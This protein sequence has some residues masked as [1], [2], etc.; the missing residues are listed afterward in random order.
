MECTIQYEE[1]K[2]IILKYIHDET[3]WANPLRPD[4]EIEELT[5]M[6][7][8][9]QHDGSCTVSFEYMFNED[10]LSKNDRSHILV[11][12]VLIGPFGRLI[13][14]QLKATH[15]GVAAKLSYTPLE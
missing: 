13:Q 3:G 2:K 9:E 12:S 11:G 8:I 4:F 1:I 6:E 7:I 15:K 5:I 10:G 14:K